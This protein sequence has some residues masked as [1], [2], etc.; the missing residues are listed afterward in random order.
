LEV[1][2]TLKRLAS[3]E[4][5]ATL[6]RLASLEVLATL[7]RFARLE[8]LATLKRLA[9][10]EV[11]ATLKRLA[12]LEFLATL[13]RL[14]RLEILRVLGYSTRGTQ[15]FLGDIGF[16]SGLE[17]A[18]QRLFLNGHAGLLFSLF[19]FCLRFPSH[20][21]RAVQLGCQTDFPLDR[22]P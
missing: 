2:T 10:L 22:V 20:V 13:K 4:V 11:L 18:D 9:R 1:L 21:L 12:R 15:I 17:C 8:V 3:L 19:E 5:L 16:L 6:K 7:K 14:A